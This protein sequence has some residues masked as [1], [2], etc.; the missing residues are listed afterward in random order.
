MFFLVVNTLPS[1]Y[2]KCM[3][4]KLNGKNYITLGVL[5]LYVLFVILGSILRKLQVSIQKKYKF[6]TLYIQQRA[7][8]CFQFISKVVGLLCSHRHGRGWAERFLSFFPLP[9]PADLSR[10]DIQF[11]PQLPVRNTLRF[12]D[13]K[14]KKKLSCQEYVVQIKQRPKKVIRSTE[15]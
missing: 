1:F 9:T 5:L 11:L 12:L 3:L 15:H 14:V 7:I 2:I 6:N 4:F 10:K 13:G 8:E